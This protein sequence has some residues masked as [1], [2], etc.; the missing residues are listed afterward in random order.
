VIRERLKKQP[1]FIPQ[2]G[3]RLAGICGWKHW[4]RR[5]GLK[6]RQSLLIPPQADNQLLALVMTA[7]LPSQA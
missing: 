3:I 7:K 2:Q 5:C 6:P 1:L 4:D